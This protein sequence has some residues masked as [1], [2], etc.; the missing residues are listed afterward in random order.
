MGGVFS[1]SLMAEEIPWIHQQHGLSAAILKSLL[2]TDRNQ[3]TQSQ[4]L[5]LMHS[6]CKMCFLFE[7]A[8]L[9]KIPARS[10][11]SRCSV[12]PFKALCVWGGLSTL[13]MLST[14]CWTAL[15]R[16]GSTVGY[17]I[18]KSRKPWKTSGTP[19][20]FSAVERKRP[21]CVCGL[22][23]SASPLSLCWP[24]HQAP[25]APFDGR[26][27]PAL[28]PLPWQPLLAQWPCWC[29][30]SALQPTTACCFAVRWV[31]PVVQQFNSGEHS[32]KSRL[33]HDLRNPHR[34]VPAEWTHLSTVRQRSWRLQELAL[35]RGVQDLGKPEVEELLLN[36]LAPFLS[37]EEKDRLVGWITWLMQWSSRIF[38]HTHFI[39]EA[40]FCKSLCRLPGKSQASVWF[41]SWL[42][43]SIALIHHCTLPQ[44]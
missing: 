29:A 24:T 22:S 37:E 5:N 10:H 40:F 25:A 7:Q 18:R 43:S 9:P 28:E 39:S 42:I 36:W 20:C 3:T 44:Q 21:F 12:S 41:L 14:Q 13:S 2:G 32:W 26:C 8:V 27:P 15:K 1:S 23:G 19:P 34:T 17:A 30:T 11:P 35:W 4:R 6:N 33:T 31:L 38:T 16:R